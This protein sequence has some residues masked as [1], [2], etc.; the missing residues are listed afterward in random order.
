M[1]TLLVLLDKEFR[2]FFRNAFL[3][4]LAI[5]FPIMVMLVIP[6]VTTMDV[7]HVGVSV[8]DNDHSTISR[9]I[10]GKIEASDYFSLK[11]ITENYEEAFAGIESGDVDVILVIP[12]DFE[13]ALTTASPKRI[14]LDVNGINS[15][16]GGLGSQYTIQ[17]LMQTVTEIQQEQG[18]VSSASKIVVENRYNPT[19]NY[20]FFMIPALMIMLLIVLCGFLPALNLVGEKEKG[21]IEQINVTPVN[22]FTFTLAKLIPYW[23]VGFIVLSIAMLL[24]WLVYGLVPQGSLLSIYLAALLFVLTMSGM[25]V[26][27]ANYSSTMQQTMFVMFFFVLIFILMSGLFTPIDSMPQWAQKVTYVLP[28]RYFIEVMRSVYLKGAL[29]SELWVNYVA[30]TISSILFCCAAAWSYKKQS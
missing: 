11:G 23:L 1:K 29:F 3:P 9:R 16:K 10:I 28:P 5:I 4:K 14:E 25:G 12:A 24:A 19:L 15:L 6:W 30:L 20:K 26:I 2:Q 17:L 21:T 8:V 22:R 27:I 13:Q 18:V 7:R